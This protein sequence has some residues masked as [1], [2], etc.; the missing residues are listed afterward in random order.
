MNNNNN[1]S[2]GDVTV[3]D[4]VA[5][6]T[7]N[8]IE[9]YTPSD[10]GRSFLFSGSCHWCKRPLYHDCFCELEYNSDFGRDDDYEE[11][12]RT[13][14][15]LES[16]VPGE[17][18]D[19]NGLNV[20]DSNV[21]HIYTYDWECFFWNEYH[22]NTFVGNSY[23]MINWNMFSINQYSL[24]DKFENER[25]DAIY[26]NLNQLATLSQET[27]GDYD[28]PAY[29]INKGRYFTFLTWLI[30]SPHF[31]FLVNKEEDMIDFNK[32]LKSIYDVA[33]WLED[34]IY[35]W[36]EEGFVPV[37]HNYALQTVDVDEECKNDFL[38]TIT[39]FIKLCDSILKI[40][41][42]ARSR[43]YR[44]KTIYKVYTFN[45]LRKAKSDLINLDCIQHILSVM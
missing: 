36:E 15:I 44:K 2:S 39:D 29:Y 30:K 34:S 31:A 4:Q 21:E 20:R 14:V 1:N 32:N 22:Q 40:Q 17:Y 5:N 41:R 37:P 38:D 18:L 42:W 7:P 26:K 33:V 3:V 19:E 28:N 10:I 23:K 6:V 8:N 11:D 27:N 45:H 9:N 13:H 12:E 25:Y 43:I 16:Y 35:R 24:D